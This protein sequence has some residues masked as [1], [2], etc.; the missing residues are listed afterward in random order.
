MVDQPCAAPDAFVPPPPP[1]SD[2]DALG[3]ALDE[4]MA[5]LGAA[6]S[7]A[8][9]AGVELHRYDLLE[10]FDRLVESSG[11]PIATTLHWQDRDLRTSP[12]G[13]RGL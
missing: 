1:I 13:D 2:P 10:S 7:P 12:P 5:L 6:R 3:E 11:L 8:I 4:V 9:L